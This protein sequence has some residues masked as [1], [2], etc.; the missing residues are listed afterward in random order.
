VA[1]DLRLVPDT[2]DGDP[3]ELAAEGPRDRSTEARLPNPRRPHEAQNRPRGIR[4]QLADSQILQD[5]VL[6]A[7]EVVVVGVQDLPRVTEVQVVLS[8]DAPWKLH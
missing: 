7:V 6:D 1:T 8:P 4:V 2:A 3:L 5:S